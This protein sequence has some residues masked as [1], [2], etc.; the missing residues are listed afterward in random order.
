MRSVGAL[1][2]PLSDLRVSARRVLIATMALADQCSEWYVKD[3]A[4][5]WREGAGEVSQ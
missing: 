1:R 5:S 4:T 3:G 2:R